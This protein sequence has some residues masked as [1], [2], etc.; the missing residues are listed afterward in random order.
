MCV[1]VLVGA[2]DNTL[3]L[4]IVAGMPTSTASEQANCCIRSSCPIADSESS[5]VFFVFFYKFR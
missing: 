5:L 1:C 4:Q 3:L 2:Y